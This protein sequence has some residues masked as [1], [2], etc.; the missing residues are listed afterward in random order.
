MVKCRERGLKLPDA[1][2]QIFDFA[3]GDL[4]IMHWRQSIQFLSLEGRYGSTKTCKHQNARIRK[5][6]QAMSCPY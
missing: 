6:S 5:I 1:L 4:Y 3:A 2:P